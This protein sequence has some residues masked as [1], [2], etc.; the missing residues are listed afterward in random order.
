MKDVMAVGPNFPHLSAPLPSLLPP[1]GV[2]P[3]SPMGCIELPQTI[4]L[5]AGGSVLGNISFKATQ[6]Y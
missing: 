4:K 5:I 3:R 2:H 1:Q 6:I